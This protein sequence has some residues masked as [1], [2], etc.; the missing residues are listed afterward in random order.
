MRKLCV[1]GIIC[2]AVGVLIGTAP[3][4]AQRFRFDEYGQPQ[5]LDNLDVRCMIQDRRGVLWI[6]TEAGLF[7]FD[8][9]R[10]LAVTI[11]SEQ[12]PE[13]ITGLVEDGSGRI[14]ASTMDT[15]FYLDD[16]GAHA[17][18]P[19]KE[20]FAF[21][22]TNNLA[23]DPDDP[24][25]IY[26]VSRHAL[27]DAKAEPGQAGHAWLHFPL[28]GSKLN[29]L[30][31]QVES[32]DALPGG[33]LWFG[34]GP[35][36]CAASGDKVRMYGLKDG[37]PAGPWT[38][39]FLDR[40]QR[41]WA[42]SENHVA[43]FDPARQRFDT[44]DSELAGSTLGVRNPHILQ[45]PQGRILMNVDNGLARY[46]SGHW[47]VFRQKTDLPPY[48]ITCLLLDRQNSVWVGLDGHGAAR[49]LGYNQWESLTTSNG[50]TSDVVWNFA[51]DARGNFWLATESNLERLERSSQKMTPQS[52]LNSG[53]MSRIQTLA[54]TTDG[55][56]WSGSD[57]GKVIDYDPATRIARTAAQ[58]NGVF[59]V[60]PDGNGRIWISSLA[61]LYS[62]NSSPGVRIVEHSL[63]PAPQGK[64]YEGVRDSKGNL[65]F[66]A[67]SGLYRL[68]GSTWTHIRLPSDYQP[69][70]SAQ[71]ALARDGTI[72]LSGATA[73]L[74][75]FR[76][77]G[78]EG[79]ELARWTAAQIGSSNVFLVAFDQRGWL[80]AGTDRGLAVLKDQQ[81]H[82]LTVDDGLIWNDINSSA[83]LADTDGSIWI[84]TSGGT[85]HIL[86]PEELFN[87]GPLPLLVSDVRIGDR[88]LST[89]APTS[90]PWGHHPLT[91]YLSTLDFTRANQTTF[92]Y[93]IEGV[94]ED[95]QDSPRHDLR[96]PP[97]APGRYSLVVVAVDAA[98]G[99][100]SAP[101]RIAFIITPPWWRTNLVLGFE[102]ATGLVLLFF[103]W[104]WSLRMYIARQ[105]RLEELVQRRTS[106]LEREKTELLKTRAAFE[107]Q[108]RH[109]ALTG[110][111]NHGAILSA[112]DLAMHRAE[113]DRTPLGLVL[114][115]LD[116]FKNVNDTYG[117][118]TGDF[119]LEQYAQ[120]IKSVI[121][122]YDSAGRYGGEE[123]LLILPGLPLEA[124]A[125]RLAVI[126]A[127]L[128]KEPFIFKETSIRVT[129]S[130]GFAQHRPGIDD[131]NSL[132]D[133]ADRALYAAKG[134]GRNRIE[135]LENPGIRTASIPS[136]GSAPVL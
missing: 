123:I 38:R 66:I 94:D 5:G 93:H 90:I 35:E 104:R 61:G 2:V 62:V 92:R 24:D 40:E 100:K 6:G 50:L 87:N 47:T 45:D 107:V 73:P 134:N 131:V 96:Y 3:A 36:I 17:I 109:D 122:D 101:S 29:P 14:W 11:P 83:F 41:L 56:L 54:F 77:H 102:I 59:Q 39:L 125:D 136:R 105:R 129:C 48:Q 64:C 98:T 30:P 80:W 10:F 97:L 108:A 124:A 12:N 13:Y 85:S 63:P 42:R 116:H 34:C 65:W 9:H 19:P 78:D 25:H 28:D 81:W 106:E 118:L 43:R 70:F 4:L 33:Q 68:T 135:I 84:G 31:G 20:N 44:V 88:S 117:H 57:N 8:G 55:H 82:S 32:I 91:A 51:R 22:L 23:A 27:Y 110:M 86:H 58:L 89:G 18:A 75:Q 113:R 120:R 26:L 99:R 71:I 74:S 132:V 52:S 114:A 130:F 72:W 119:I 37:L 53:P 95:W 21:D 133:R 115:D 67:D 103:L 121:R 126:H 46:D 7:Q 112:L 111:L 79:E 127:A 128:C 49:W 60:L 69:T 1:L 15:L 16:A 76:I